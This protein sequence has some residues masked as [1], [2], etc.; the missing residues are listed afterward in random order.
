MIVRP[1]VVIDERDQDALL[2]ELEARRPGY[3]P[4]WRPGQRDPGYALQ[5]I[6]ARYAQAIINR[7]RQ[8][9][10]KNKLAFLDMLGQKLSP[11]RAARTPVI[12]Q[13]VSDATS[14]AAPAG[15]A[16]A[17]PPPPGSNQQ[18]VFETESDVGLT[19]GKLVQV[20]SLWPG[21]DEYIDHSADF[22]AGRTLK[23]FEAEAMTTAPHQLYLSHP[24]LLNL[25]GN[26]VLSVEFQLLHP[27]VDAL[28][29]VWEYWDGQV[30]RGF[31]AQGTDCE[32]RTV[33]A[34]LSPEPKDSNDATSGLTGSGVVKLIADCAKSDKTSVN[35]V[36][37]YWIRGRLNQSLPPDPAKPLP[38]AESIRLSSLVSQPMVARLFDTTPRV[39]SDVVV[40]VAPSAAIALS[41]IGEVALAITEAFATVSQLRLS[42]LVVNEAGQPLGNASVVISDPNR[43]SFGQR[44]VT[45][46]LNGEFSISLDDFGLKNELLFEVTFFETRAAAIVKLPPNTNS[47]QLTFKLSALSLTKAFND[48]TQ[49][50]TTKPFYPFGQQPQPGTVFYFNNK[51]IFSKPGARFRMYL[52]RTSAPSDKLKTVNEPSIK[53][54]EPQVIWEYWNG[55]EWTDLVPSN[56]EPVKADFTTTEIL[57]FRVPVDLVTVEV[58]KDVDLWMR[59]RLVS[60]GY[61]FYQKMTFKTGTTDPDNNNFTLLVTQPPVLAA[62]VLGYSWQYGPFYPETVLT[63]N[64][65]RY[66][67]HTYEAMW[68]GSSFQPYQ[69]I[70]DITAA[71]YLGFDQKPPTAN[72][73]IFFD[74][75]EKATGAA[76]AHF[77]WEYWDGFQWNHVAVGDETAQ[78]TA[79]GILSFIAAD[80]STA[81]ARFG[82]ALYWLRGRLKE[83]GPPSR[84]TVAGIYPNAVRALQ[85][86]T[87]IDVDLGK[88]TGQPSEV[89]HILQIPVIPGERL[90]VLELSGARAN[91][92]WRLIALELSRGNNDIVRKLEAQLGKETLPGD[93][94][95]GDLRLR[96]DKQKRVS[97]V[98]VRWYAQPNLF[99]SAATARHYAM[100]RA[101]GLVFFGDGVNGRTLPLDAAVNVRKFQSGGGADGNVAAMTIKQL[102]GAVSGV[103]AVFNPRAAEGGADGETLEAF[104]LRAPSSVRHRG[105]ALTIGDYEAM[106]REASSAVSVVKAIANRNPSG[107]TLPGWLTI[108]IIPE[109][110]EPRPYPTRG[111]RDEVLRYLAERAPAGLAAG[112]HI[113]V[114]GPMYFAVDVSA[115][116]VPVLDSQAGLVETR[117]REALNKFLHPLHGGT[118]GEGWDFG[119]GVYLSDVATVLESVEGLDYAELIQLLVNDEVHGDFAEVPRDRIVVA[120]TIRLK[121]KG[122]RR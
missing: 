68:P 15:T 75:I 8:S 24:V 37:G 11:A 10:E 51:E 103:Q 81:L 112:G 84:V 5:L 49:L 34:S 56:T 63:F 82:T 116:I 78:L 14:G 119:R 94:V 57:D 53:E 108:F 26:V 106:V 6:A 72:I 85:Q 80:D 47:V 77:A 109:S 120:G 102:L 121:L 7:L 59:A 110:Q 79:P 22:L 90:E 76:A 83:D 38:E 45:T 36:T 54:L 96:R 27:A 115:T 33:N 62:A 31:A 118:S 66:E 13:L 104:R 20:F 28:E 117:A 65:F 40:V 100:D 16:V 35:G 29:I 114:T 18:M 52:P 61:G 91:V 86:R 32:P 107:R 44:T 42:G 99:F 1:S 41:G 111:M 23:L 3:V 4:E 19:A 105:R 25:S 92:E 60:G 50:D 95:E 64:D 67:D 21:R 69:R 17:A 87:Y 122:A 39:K 30:W 70:Q 71:L 43:E 98:W 46:G 12:F 88:A 48:G 9:P 113:Y 74:I 97:E 55:R 89:F 101:R 2:Q 73:G 93:I 58:N